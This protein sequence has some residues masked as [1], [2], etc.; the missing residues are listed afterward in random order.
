M[1]VVVLFVGG[2]LFVV[3]IIVV[4]WFVLFLELGE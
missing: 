3:V 2:N 1:F 4:H